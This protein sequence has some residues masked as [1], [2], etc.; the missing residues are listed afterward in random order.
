MTTLWQWLIAILVWLSADPVAIDQEP[1][2]AAAAVAAARASLLVEAEPQPGPAP[3]ACD[4]GGT[5]VKG[6]WKPDGKIVAPC[7]CPCQRCV[8]ERA[9]ASPATCPDGNCPKR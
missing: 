4:C 2:K 9:K 3:A 5:C 7:K 8:A 1:A 6:I